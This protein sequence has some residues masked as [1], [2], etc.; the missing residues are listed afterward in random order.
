MKKKIHPYPRLGIFI[1]TNGSTYNDSLYP[2]NMWKPLEITSISKIYKKNAN[3]YISHGEFENFKCCFKKQHKRKLE[4]LNYKIQSDVLLPSTTTS[5]IVQDISKS[6]KVSNYVQ[7][8]NKLIAF[9]KKNLLNY[10]TLAA[11][12]KIRSLDVDTY[13]NPLWN[14]STTLTPFDSF[15]QSG[16]NALSKFKKRYSSI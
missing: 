12:S 3:I 2:I 6:E 14:G 4:L 11:I 10:L 13:T 16:D 8:K 1:H 15:E 9:H 5:S 7:I